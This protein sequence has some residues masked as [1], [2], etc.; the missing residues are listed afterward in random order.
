MSLPGVRIVI[1]I[2]RAAEWAADGSNEL[3]FQ[4]FLDGK[5]VRLS[6]DGIAAD[7]VDANGDGRIRRIRRHVVRQR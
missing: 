4:R 1:E 7:P 2:L 6:G 5:E 3:D